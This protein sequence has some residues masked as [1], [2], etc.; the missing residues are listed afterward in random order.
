[1]WR[2]VVTD[3]NLSVFTNPS[4]KM[5]AATGVL[6]ENKMRASAVSTS[7]MFEAIGVSCI[8]API[9]VDSFIIQRKSTP[10]GASVSVLKLVDQ[11]LC[12]WSSNVKTFSKI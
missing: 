10:W 11:L 9:V 12:V 4:P 7:V 2:D 8:N 1:M 6:Y 3:Q 5:Y